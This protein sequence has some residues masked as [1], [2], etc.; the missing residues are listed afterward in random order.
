M[1][2]T[3]VTLAEAAIRNCLKYPDSGFRPHKER[4]INI[5]T[6]FNNKKFSTVLQCH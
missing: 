5:L 2:L 4:D 6:Y 3:I 1:L